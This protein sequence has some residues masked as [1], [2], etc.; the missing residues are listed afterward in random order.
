MTESDAWGVALGATRFV[1]NAGHPRESDLRVTPNLA[2][3]LTAA[4]GAGSTA[5]RQ[6]R[7]DL[8]PLVALAALAVIAAEWLAILWSGWRNLAR[9]R[10]RSAT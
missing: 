3:A 10:A 7:L 8:W 9:P 5:P 6:E 2:P 4:S 1:V